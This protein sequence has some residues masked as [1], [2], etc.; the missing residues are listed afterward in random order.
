MKSR[1]STFFPIVLVALL[2]AA[3]WWLERVVEL[4]EPQASAKARHDPD[5]VVDRFTVLRLGPDGKLASTLAAVK[6]LH[7]PDDETTELFEPR[8]VQ[9]PQGAPPVRMRGDRGTVTKNG[10]EVHIHDNVVVTRDAT[11]DRPELRVE[12]TYLHV[13]PKEE[14]A[15]TPEPVVITEGDSRLAGVGM[16]VRGKTRELELHARVKGSF[17]PANTARA[18]A[19]AAAPATRA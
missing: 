10:D 17:A 5:A 19:A 2:A 3:T 14:V 18:P 15:R 12:T 13:F 4:S 7:F 11:P 1:A 6:M 9:Y 16:E 8:V